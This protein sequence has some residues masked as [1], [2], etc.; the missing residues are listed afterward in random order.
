MQLRDRFWPRVDKSGDC[1]VW[2]GGRIPQ[3]YGAV[4]VD[5][6]NHPAHRVAWELTIGPIPPG[7]FVLHHC[8]NM[9]CVRPS[10]LWLGT[11]LDNMADK[12]QKG[13]AATGLRN[14]SHT[15]PERRPHR[16]TLT[17]GDVRAMRE[18]A[19]KG[20]SHRDLATRYMVS[21]SHV[22]RIL[23]NDVWRI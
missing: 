14:G 15:R 3:G 11:Q 12:A 20:S 13:R 1:W 8:D 4:W 2:I 17:R 5:G 6:R 7:L 10:H 19:E 22:S 16:H 23:S 18:L 9:P 21:R